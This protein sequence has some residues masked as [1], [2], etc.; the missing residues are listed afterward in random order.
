MVVWDD[1]TPGNDKIM[2]CGSLD[3]K[4][5][6]ERLVAKGFEEGNKRTAVHLPRHL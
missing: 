4:E 2:I 3:P 1:I 6:K 5:M